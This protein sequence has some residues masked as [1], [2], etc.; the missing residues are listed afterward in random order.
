MERHAASHGYRHVPIGITNY[1]KHFA[2]SDRNP[3]RVSMAVICLS[4]FVTWS[5]LPVSQ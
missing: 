5:R 3:A 4:Q 2:K 1:E